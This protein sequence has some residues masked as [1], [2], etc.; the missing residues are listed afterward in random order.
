MINKYKKELKVYCFEITIVVK[1]CYEEK[2]NFNIYIVRNHFD[3][4]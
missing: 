2:A 3:N 4:V 1:L